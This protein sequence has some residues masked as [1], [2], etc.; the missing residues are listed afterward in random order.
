MPILSARGGLSARSYGMFGSIAP[1]GA[2]ESIQT[3][4]VPVATVYPTITFTS[5][6]STYKH[7]QIRAIGLSTTS[8]HGD[9][10]F[11]SDSA[12]NYTYHALGGTGSVAYAEASAPRS[13]IASIVR[14]AGSANAV[15]CAVIEILDYASN[16][17]YKTVRS[18]R[19]FDNNGTGDISLISGMWMNT[20]S[21]ITSITITA[22]G[23]TFTSYSSFALYGMKG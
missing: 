6:P 15:G 14:M 21:A 7:L 16:N 19:G 5:I 3:V 17:K 20:S 13:D 1:S 10:R 4:T 18:L 11:N 23:G 22:R 8:N 9:L 2:Y 12:N